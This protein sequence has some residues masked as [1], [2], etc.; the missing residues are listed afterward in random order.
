[1][2]SFSFS[3]S[4]DWIS[5]SSLSAMSI[6]L[7]GRSRRFF[8]FAGV[9]FLSLAVQL[10]LQPDD[11]LLLGA[12]GL[13]VRVEF[14]LKRVNVGRSAARPDRAP[15]RFAGRWRGSLGRTCGCCGPFVR[16]LGFGLG[17]DDFLQLLMLLYGIEGSRTCRDQLVV[18]PR[19]E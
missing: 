10:L 15:G 19:Q 11:L 6:T 9:I 18:I 13:T 3:A 16:G 8:P 17:V 5:L 2:I 7:R 4:S 1:M 14:S 12:D